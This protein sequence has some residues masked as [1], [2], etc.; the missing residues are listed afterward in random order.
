[1]SWK[2]FAAVV[3]G[4]TSLMGG[5]GTIGGTHHRR[6]HC[7]RAEKRPQ[8]HGRVPVLA[9]GGDGRGRRCRQST[10]TRYV[11]EC[12]RYFDTTSSANPTTE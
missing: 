3:I 6:V 4:G 5:V 1:M 12:V 11:K 8:S 9:D 2:P 7:E 10:R